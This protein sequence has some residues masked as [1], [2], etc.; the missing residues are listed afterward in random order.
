[1]SITKRAFFSSTSIIWS[2]ILNVIILKKKGR[3]SCP[4]KPAFHCCL[5]YWTLYL[6]NTRNKSLLYSSLFSSSAHFI[7]IL[8]ALI[9]FTFH[10]S[11]ECSQI[12]RLIQKT[13]FIFILMQ[14][15]TMIN[16]FAGCAHSIC[17]LWFLYDAVTRWHLTATLPWDLCRHFWRFPWEANYFISTRAT[18]TVCV[19][20][21]ARWLKWSLFC[22]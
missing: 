4:F 17:P 18:W 9:I 8:I 15:H 12:K 11:L 13:P 16:V 21:C 10:P 19:C 22:H 1:M 6:F 2:V 3:K 7:A 14:K 20:V 5:F